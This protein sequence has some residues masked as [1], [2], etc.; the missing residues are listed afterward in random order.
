MEAM[1][2]RRFARWQPRS[3]SLSAL[4]PRQDGLLAWLGL[5]EAFDGCLLCE[6]ADGSH[7]C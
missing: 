6:C 1:L 4:G 2:R 3:A 5:A 7:D